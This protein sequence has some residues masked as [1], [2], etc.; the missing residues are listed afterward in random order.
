MNSIFGQH[1]SRPFPTPR[2]GILLLALVA[3]GGWVRGE[4][5]AGKTERPEPP[6]VTPKPVAST[7]ASMTPLSGPPTTEVT[8]TGTDLDLITSGTYG[9]L[10]L[11]PDSLARESPTRLRARVPLGAVAPATFT[12]LSNA[13][14]VASPLFTLTFPAPAVTG[15][16]VPAGRAGAAVAI[17]GA[18]L[19]G[20][21]RVAFGD[22]P[23]TTFRLVAADRIEATVPPRAVSGPITVTT[24]GG[25][26]ASGTFA[27]QP[28]LTGLE[29]QAGPP[30]TALTLR[31]S[32]LDPLE[33]WVRIGDRW[34][35]ILGGNA[36]RTE[37]TVA[38]PAGA[39]AGAGAVTLFTRGGRAASPQAFTLNYLAPTVTGLAPATGVPGTE[40]TLTGANLAGVTEVLYGGAALYPGT[41]RV[42]SHPAPRILA[43]VPFNGGNGTFTLRN[44]AGGAESAPFT[45]TPVHSRHAFLDQALHPRWTA[46][47]PA[48]DYPAASRT[49]Q[50][51]YAWPKAPIFHAY[52]PWREDDPLGAMRPDH[53]LP[54]KAC[55]N[56]RLPELFREALPAD[57]RAALG[58]L[59]VAP[60]PLELYVVSQNQP[61]AA[62]MLFRPHYWLYPDLGYQGLPG[63]NRGRQ[64]GMGL[65]GGAPFHFNGHA[66]GAWLTGEATATSAHHAG[67]S[68]EVPTY[69]INSPNN[70]QVT[71]LDP[72]RTRAVWSIVQ[73]LLN[74]IQP[75]RTAVTLHLVLNDGDQTALE[76]LL[77]AQRSVR[78]LLAA[79]AGDPVLGASPA[80]AALQGLLRAE[81]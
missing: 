68:E 13:G 79:L 21:T 56:L 41:W 10:A 1:R 64:A 26:A 20:A 65:Y 18:H 39:A 59:A 80:T 6:K 57:V 51:G 34:A 14:P 44:P 15:L 73:D 58:A 30:G 81:P 42:V 69:M 5:R 72:A 24:P 25:Q 16:S 9:G 40:V 66:A 27:V 75:G 3:G 55:L 29:P 52:H 12:F 70:L 19:Y 38:A 50:Y 60:A 53:D 63:D 33:A 36:D 62:P 77:P 37:L 45:V 46:L 35:A 17:T 74:P 78:G 23:A 61:Y 76:A 28:V 43:Q 4:E 71:G 67:P 8:F 31:G 2:Y 54:A 48:L 22:V 11:D 7:V 49:L 32:G 47:Y